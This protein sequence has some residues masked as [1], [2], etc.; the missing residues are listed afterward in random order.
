MKL[1]KVILIKYKCKYRLN[2]NTNT[3]SSTSFKKWN[4]QQLF[5]SSTNANTNMN[6]NSNLISNSNE[7]LRNESIKYYF[8]QVQIQI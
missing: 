4:C 5:W 8:D 3:H 1:S 7:P 6:T 2:S